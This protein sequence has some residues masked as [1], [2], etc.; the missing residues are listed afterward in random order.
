MRFLK[1]TAAIARIMAGVLVVSAGVA[2]AGNPV[3]GK[4]Q[5]ERAS[6]TGDAPAIARIPSVLISGHVKGLYPGRTTKLRGRV[7]NPGSRA[8]LVTHV[9]AAVG[10][11]GQ[12]CGSKFLKVRR[13]RGTVRV[14]AHDRHK[15]ILKVTMLAGAP[16]SCQGATFPLRFHARVRAA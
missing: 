5:A 13:S 11:T 8:V 3:S 15:V 12:A 4:T 9:S 2:L 16:E 6:G 1:G 14:A 10:K 7:H